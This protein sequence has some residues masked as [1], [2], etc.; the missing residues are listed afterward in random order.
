[1]TKTKRNLINCEIHVWGVSSAFWES[2]SE[3]ALTMGEAAIS[4]LQDKDRVLSRGTGQH[5]DSK[6]LLHEP[7]GNKG[8]L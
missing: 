5:H 8:I 2:I 7:D 1:M 4:R 3:W 6:T